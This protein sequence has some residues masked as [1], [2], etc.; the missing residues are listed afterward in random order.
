MA[1]TQSDLVRRTLIWVA[2]SGV[3]E[4]C[5][6]AGARNAPLV[7]ALL[8][9]EWL[10]IRHFFE[11]R[12]AGFFALGRAM[13][14]RRPVAVVTT[15]G[16]AVAELLPAMI[17]AHY[18]GL[19]VIAL[20]ADRP[21]RYRGSGAP[22][23]IEQPN[24]F[25]PYS[26]LTLDVDA[27]SG[28]AAFEA[29]AP[30]DLP[31]HLNLCLEEPLDTSLEEI[32]FP[33]SAALPSETK[34][35]PPLTDA[36]FSQLLDRQPP[37]FVAVA[38]IHPDDA[39]GLA[40]ALTELGVP[41]LAEATANLSGHT[42]LQPFLIPPTDAFVHEL[43]PSSIL[44][45]GA[46]PSGR[47]WRD[48][49][50]QPDVHVINLSPTGHPGLARQ[51]GVETLRLTITQA[52][53]LLMTTAWRAS[54]TPRPIPSLRTPNT[55]GVPNETA[56]LMELAR[57]IPEDALVFLGNSL[58]IREWNQAVGSSRSFRTF[59]NRGANGIDGL[60]STFLGLSAEEPE[61]WLILGDLSALY[62]LAAPWILSQLP[63]ANRRIVILNNGGGRIFSRVE[64]LRS[65][66]ADTRR[67]IENEHGRTFKPWAD[68]WDLEHR[69]ARNPADLKNLPEGNIIVE[70]PTV[71]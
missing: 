34:P 23:A 67:V 6:A 20:T 38:G 21:K 68:L 32:A 33:A 64:S 53:H 40:T 70:I 25:G 48:L 50:E 54:G 52:S 1:L 14:C 8:R 5:V 63:P 19:P 41:V 65:L 2:R 13:A 7:T 61:S 55:P 49:E 9:C 42:G 43:R 11:E 35:K 71:V 56:W 12:C 16:T 37:D 28:V 18:Q 44:R 66:S 45:I 3:S 36:G 17:E 31:S 27:E 62:D 26:A 22:Q 4:V 30:W 15:S 29:T 46:V 59:A 51:G 24:L 69:M 47:W 57:C 58:P 60:V 39:S 10:T